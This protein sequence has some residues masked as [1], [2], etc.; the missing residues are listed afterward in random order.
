MLQG[1]GLPKKFWNEAVQCAAY[2]LNR[3]P[4]RENTIIPAEKWYGKE[5]DYSKLRTFGCIAYLHIPDQKRKKLDVKSRTCVFVGYAPQG[6]R[7]WDLETEQIVI[8]RDIRFDEST[9]F[10]DTIVNIVRVSAVSSESRET[11]STVDADTPHSDPEITEEQSPSTTPAPEVR[12]SDRVR[13]KPA[14]LQD[15]EV[16]MNV[17]EALL[18]QSTDTEDADVW[19][20]AKRAELNSMKKHDVWTLVPKE[21]DMKV[22]KTNW[23]LRTKE[24]GVRKARLVAAGWDW[25]GLEE[26]VYAPVANTITIRTFFVNAVRAGMQIDQ[27]D[28]RNAFLHGEIRDEVYVTQP[29]GYV[30]D[31]SLVC[32]LNKAIYGLNVSPKIFN[33]CFDEYVTNVLNF[34]RS[35][36]D[37]CLYTKLVNG[38]TVYV[39]I[40]V[41][42]ILVASVNQKLIDDLK[43]ALKKKFDVADLG[44]IKNFL[45]IN[46]DY[47]PNEKVMY[48]QQEK[49]IRK[50][51]DHFGLQ[52]AV[53]IG[54]PIEPKLQLPKA[55]KLSADLPYRQLIGSLLFV[56]IS[57][58]PDIS[59]AVN[60]LSQFQM[61]YD[62]THFEHAKRIARYLKGT[63]G[64]KLKIAEVENSQPLESFVDADWANDCN[65]RR[66]VS[67]YFITHFG[68]PIAWRTMK[69]NNVTLSST[70]AEIVAVSTLI[71]D[72]LLWVINLLDDFGVHLCNPVPIFEDNQ[73]TISNLTE[74]VTTGSKR[75]HIDT[76]CKFVRELVKSNQLHFIFVSSNCQ[77]ADIFTKG[78]ARPKFVEFRS[79]L[80]L[81]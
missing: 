13:K 79:N 49:F 14:R 54:T 72:H 31:K 68:N 28:I 34:R 56:N 50:L 27:L 73:G 47:R 22:I 55:E 61:C 18:C 59:Y 71:N 80:S 10:K 40:Y 2:V 6:Y 3:C 45:G 67:G 42:D 62:H 69:Q 4:T 15:Y 26:N 23:I 78:L 57:T 39:L 1:S 76:R 58:R 75:K 9:M 30:Q 60:Y 46:V 37:R 81:V 74:K 11:T 32:R 5:A 53:P 20:E 41:D 7:L 8:G 16:S 12:R 77:P 52:D 70:E 65:T 33:E 36:K 17:C 48:L 19:V 24:N 66:S 44:Q 21:K 25:S 38:E 35:E 63:I 51:L 64:L 43:F 29:P